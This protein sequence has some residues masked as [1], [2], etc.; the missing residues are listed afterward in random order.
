MLTNHLYSVRPV[1][2][3]IMGGGPS[4]AGMARG[5]QG[6]GIG[7]V[8]GW[9]SGYDIADFP[10]LTME[11]LMMR[12]PDRMKRKDIMAMYSPAQTGQ[13]PVQTPAMQAPYQAPTRNNVF[14]AGTGT[15]MTLSSMLSRQPTL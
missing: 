12:G 7:K 4:G 11:S 2:G 5:P 10:G 9:F 15:P 6:P 3:D 1:G 13:P 8:P 14:N